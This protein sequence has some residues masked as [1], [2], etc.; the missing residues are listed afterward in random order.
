MSIRLA[1]L[2]GKSA[3]THQVTGPF[4]PAVTLETPDQRLGALEGRFVRNW[5]GV[6]NREMDWTALKLMLEDAGLEDVEYHNLAGGIAAIHRG[7]KP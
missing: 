5:D 3:Q 7:V 2:N 6:R 1:E 4:S